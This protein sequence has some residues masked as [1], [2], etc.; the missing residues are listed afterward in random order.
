[1]FESYVIGS[2][3]VQHFLTHSCE[4]PSLVDQVQYTDLASVRRQFIIKLWEI[5]YNCVTGYDG[6]RA[7][8]IVP[9][10]FWKWHICLSYYLKMFM[11]KLLSRPFEVTL[12]NL[13]LSNGCRRDW[14]RPCLL[15]RLGRL[16]CVCI[17]GFARFFGAGVLSIR[18]AQRQEQSYWLLRGCR[19][20]FTGLSRAW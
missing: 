12:I 15:V 13:G 5:D 8:T 20:W 11:S 9:T 4:A 16:I 7:C 10:H 3:R 17:R 6:K 18:R 1:M 19:Q 14:C 2:V